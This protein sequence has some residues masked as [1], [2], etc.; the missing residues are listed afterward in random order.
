L[1]TAGAKTAAANMNVLMAP[2][3]AMALARFCIRIPR[4][5]ANAGASAEDQRPTAR[6]ANAPRA[7]SAK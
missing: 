3:H 2:S 5:A 1:N 7:L 4:T 6:A